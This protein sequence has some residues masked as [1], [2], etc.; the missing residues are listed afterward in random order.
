LGN[1]KDNSR[2]QSLVVVSFLQKNKTKRKQKQQKR[3]KQKNKTET[4]PE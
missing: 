3:T 4:K 2:D 1:F